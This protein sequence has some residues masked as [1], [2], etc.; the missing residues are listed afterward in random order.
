MGTPGGD[1]SGPCD[2]TRRSCSGERVAYLRTPHRQCSLQ[3]SS[4]GYICMKSINVFGCCTI[5]A[6]SC[7]LAG[8]EA[9]RGTGRKGMVMCADT[10]SAGSHLLGGES[11]WL[12]RRLLSAGLPAACAGRSTCGAP[13]RDASAAASA[14]R[15]G[16]STSGLAPVVRWPPPA[17]GDH[18]AATGFSGPS[19]ARAV[20][21]AARGSRSHARGRHVRSPGSADV[22]GGRR[23][24]RLAKTAWALQAGTDRDLAK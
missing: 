12:P 10:P 13:A 22:A 4:V 7:W 11:A 9:T 5:S 19:Q 16:T 23:R 3:A 1:G 18:D 6:S 21:A 2:A 15:Q 20:D 14:V 24:S 17:G 8:Q